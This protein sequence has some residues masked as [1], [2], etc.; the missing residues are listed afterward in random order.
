MSLSFC[1]H[2]ALNIDT[3][4]IAIDW[5]PYT[6]R[7]IIGGCGDATECVGGV[8][9]TQGRSIPRTPDTHSGYRHVWRRERK[10]SS[11]VYG[12]APKLY[13]QQSIEMHQNFEQPGMKKPQSCKQPGME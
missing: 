2:A 12:A 13:E 8:P 7:V 11:L 5:R 3:V 4:R 6:V 10:A 9:M 1:E